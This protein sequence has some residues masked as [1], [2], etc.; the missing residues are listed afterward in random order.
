MLSTLTHMTIAQIVT[1]IGYPGI[2]IAVFAESGIPIGFFLPG[3]SMIF[4]AGLLASQ[5]FFNI[6]VLTILITAA[7]ILGDNVGYWFGAYIGPSLFA[8][9][10]SRFFKQRYLTE[11][12]AFYEKYGKQAIILARFIPVVRTFAPIV[13]GIAGMRYRTFFVYNIVGGLLWAAGTCL[14]GYFLGRNIPGIS[15]YVTPIALLIVV[16]TTAPVIWK[17][18]KSHRR[19]LRV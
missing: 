12:H 16:I 18:Y 11:A 2:C 4:T 7:A 1:L 3:S 13:A 9:K 19:A 15:S 17:F 10:D 5:G 8:R 14:A 6:W